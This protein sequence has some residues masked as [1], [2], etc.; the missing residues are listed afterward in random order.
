MTAAYILQTFG[1]KSIQIAKN[2]P[3]GLSFSILEQ[4]ILYAK[5]KEMRQIL[6]KLVAIQLS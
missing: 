6:K 2:E 1:Q 5:K 3:L 4:M